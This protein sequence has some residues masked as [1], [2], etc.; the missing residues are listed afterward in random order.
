MRR[1]L[2]SKV[3]VFLIF[4]NEFCQNNSFVQ[5]TRP[6]SITPAP[7]L[8]EDGASAALQPQIDNSFRRLPSY[9]HVSQHDSL[10]GVSCTHV[11]VIEHFG[12]T[13]RDVVELDWWHVCTLESATGPEQMPPRCNSLLLERMATRRKMYSACHLGLSSCRIGGL[14]LGVYSCNQATCPLDFPHLQRQWGQHL[15]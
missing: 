2:L 9:K 4:T 5:D 1:N 15:Q 10:E 11:V 3:I 8:Q 6:F 7:Y 14:N 12:G 13:L